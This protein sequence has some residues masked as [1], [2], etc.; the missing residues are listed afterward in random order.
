MCTP[1]KHVNQRSTENRS[2]LTALAAPTPSKKTP[3]EAALKRRT[4]DN[5]IVGRAAATAPARLEKSRQQG[6]KVPFRIAPT[7][8]PG[9]EQQQNRQSEAVEGKKEH[10]WALDKDSGTGA[11]P[12]LPPRPLFRL[13]VVPWSLN[14]HPQTND[15]CRLRSSRYASRPRSS[16]PGL[17][18]PYWTVLA[19]RYRRRQ[20]R[21]SQTVKTR[22]FLL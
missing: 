9:K 6:Q 17:P 5:H 10:G 11:P 20:S 22:Y 7:Q 2:C 12:R 15:G 3:R 1:A 14:A 18:C 19:A 8:A 16:G 13:R 21:H 4:T